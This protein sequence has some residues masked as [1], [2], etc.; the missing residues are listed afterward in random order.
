M[1]YLSQCLFS[2]Q[3]S[4]ART[5]RP[6]SASMR[7]DLNERIA[8]INTLRSDMERMR[9]DKNITSGLVSQMQRDMTNKV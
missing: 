9:K 4:R 8:E 3:L 2:V 7:R 6:A 5:D 1:I